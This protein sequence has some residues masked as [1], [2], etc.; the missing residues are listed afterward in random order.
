MVFVASFFVA[1]LR[2]KAFLNISIVVMGL[3]IPVN[4]NW[5]F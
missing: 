2:S 5:I 3:G 1:F 4:L